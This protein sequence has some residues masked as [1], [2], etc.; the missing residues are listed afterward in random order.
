MT[1]P[2][3]NE[4]TLIGVVHRDPRGGKRVMGLLEKLQ[5]DFLSL[6]V[7]KYALD[8][9]VKNGLALAGRVAGFIKELNGNGKMSDDLLLHGEILGVLNTI[10][11]PFEVMVAA[12]YAYENNAGYFLMDDSGFS[13]KLLEVV[14]K[15][16]VTK[17]N[18][19]NLL[20]RPDFDYGESIEKIYDECGRILNE[21][22]LTRR[23]LGISE[24]NLDINEKRDAKIEEKLKGKMKDLPG[25]WAH[26]CGF[27][28]ILKAEGFNNMAAR[29]PNAKRILAIHYPGRRRP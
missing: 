22:P 27:T 12:K 19:V 26:I 2:S 1:I 20:Q 16:M 7:S 28:H 17:R 29:F 23:Q 8:W 5:C 4:L 10:T 14:K 25:H 21:E 18:I 15:E 6:E 11:V 13:K 9:R 24:E 3:G